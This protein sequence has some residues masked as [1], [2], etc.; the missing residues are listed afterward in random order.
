MPK[1]SRKK[2]RKDYPEFGILK[3]ETYYEWSFFRSRKAQK[4]RSR[5]RPSQLTQ[6]L[7]SSV[8]AAREAIED[9]PATSVLLDLLKEAVDIAEDVSSA[10]EEAGESMG[11]AGETQQQRAEALRELA[12]GLSDIA[13]NLESLESDEDISDEER[14]DSYQQAKDDALDLSWDPE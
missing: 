14:E 1:V 5:P 13:S 9:A 11:A 7:W 8:Y 2:A 3:G 4:S 10:Y 6:S 12:S